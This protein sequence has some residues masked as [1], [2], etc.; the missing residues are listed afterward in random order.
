MILLSALSATMCF[1][2]KH[3]TAAKVKVRGRLL[4]GASRA[5]APREDQLR[6]DIHLCLLHVPLLNRGGPS[7]WITE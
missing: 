7:S 3:L 6:R 4:L 2:A 5:V 1:R